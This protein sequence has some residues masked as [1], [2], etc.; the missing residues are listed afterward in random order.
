M[1]VLEC[2]RGKQSRPFIDAGQH[3]AVYLFPRHR[4]EQ[5]AGTIEERMDYVH[6]V[7]P[8]GQT[9]LDE[10]L[11]GGGGAEGVEGKDWEKRKRS[12]GR[13]ERLLEAWSEWGDW[14]LHSMVSVEPEARRLM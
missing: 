6:S 11:H 10:F 2:R 7:F 4:V 5:L 14:L 8:W 1:I 12:S 13:P 9:V 3:L